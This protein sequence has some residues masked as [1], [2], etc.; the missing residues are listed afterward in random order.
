MNNFKCLGPGQLNS[1]PSLE[2]PFQGSQYSGS[3]CVARFGAL[4]AWP[5]E[6][7]EIP[8]LQAINFVSCSL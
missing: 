8:T 7:Q 4:D 1:M 6:E 2:G 3:E 5:L